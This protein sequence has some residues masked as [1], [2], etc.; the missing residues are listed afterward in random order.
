MA[1]GRAEAL[2]L[3]Q[4]IPGEGPGGAPGGPQGGAPPAV[5]YKKVADDSEYSPVA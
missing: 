5:L 2:G 4:Q 3:P 1:W